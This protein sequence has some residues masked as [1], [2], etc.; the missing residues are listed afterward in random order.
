VAGPGGGV[1]YDLREVHWLVTAGWGPVGGPVGGPYG[2]PRA[3]GSRRVRARRALRRYWAVR[4]AGNYVACLWLTVSLIVVGSAYVFAP[5]YAVHDTLVA[6]AEAAAE[7]WSTA[8]AAWASS[9][10][11]AGAP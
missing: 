1:G 11:P 8:R 10:G 7:A 9:E 3:R 5:Y 6:L 2:A 4:Q